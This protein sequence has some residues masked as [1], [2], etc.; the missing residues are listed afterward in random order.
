MRVHFRR[1]T[2][3]NG[4]LILA[5]S[6]GGPVVIPHL[7]NGHNKTFFFFAYEE[8]HNTQTN[9]DGTITVP[10]QAYLAMAI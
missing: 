9:N 8:Y 4:S 6:L 7:Y 10:T 5:A 3:F 1:L 2:R